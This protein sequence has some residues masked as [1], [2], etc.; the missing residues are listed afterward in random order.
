[1]KDSLDTTQITDADVIILSEA[2]KINTT[3]QKLEFVSISLLK[4]IDVMS[5]SLNQITDTGVI[6]L[7]EALIG[8][9]CWSRVAMCL[10]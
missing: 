5:L 6:A 4:E 9:I 1:M 7:A 10:V 2:L 8:T 3:L